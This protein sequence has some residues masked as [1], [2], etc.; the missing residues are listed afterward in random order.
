MEI[1][2]IRLLVENGALVVCA[3]GGGIPIVESQSGRLEGVAAVIDKD[4]TSALLAQNLSADALI[5]LADCDGVF[6][7]FKTPKERKLDFVDAGQDQDEIAKQLRSS[8][9]F[10]AY[11]FLKKPTGFPLAPCVQSLS[12]LCS[13]FERRRA[14]LGVRSAAWTTCLRFWT[15]QKEQ[16]LRIPKNEPFI[17]KSVTATTFPIQRDLSFALFLLVPTVLFCLASFLQY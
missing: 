7:D 11:F 15:E 10:C 16:E 9:F 13:L 2:S 6:V 1:D 8:Y 17:G 4:R 14:D 5:I 3:G 12:Q